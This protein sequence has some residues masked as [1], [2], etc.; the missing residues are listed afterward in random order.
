[1]KSQYPELSELDLDI[2]NRKFE[3]EYALIFCRS[4]KIASHPFFQDFFAYSAVGFAMRIIS[5]HLFTVT[6]EVSFPVH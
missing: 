4:S 2:L 6:R 3:C 1:M 5:D